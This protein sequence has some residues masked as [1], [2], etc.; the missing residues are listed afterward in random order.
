MITTET[1]KTKIHN[2]IN[3]SNAKTG[4]NDST[5][6]DAVNE[7][8]SGYGA[9]NEETQ[10]GFLTSPVYKNVEGSNYRLVYNEDFNG[11]DIDKNYWRDSHFISRVKNRYQAWTDYYLKDSLLHL[12]IRK[13]APNR[14][15]ADDDNDVFATAIQTGEVNKLH[16]TS[17]FYHDIHPFWGLITQEG[18]YECRFKVFKATGGCHTSWWCVGIQDGKYS[19][20]PRAEID[21][22]EILA[23]ATTN[24][25]HGVHRQSDD[26]VTESYTTTAVDVDFA[27]D[28]HTVG[29]LWENGIMKWYVD[30]V[31]VDTKEINTPQYPV[32]HYLSAYKRRSGTGWTGDA[33]TTLDDV[34]FLVDYLKI[35]KK[36]ESASDTNV[37]IVSQE[38]IEVSY[39]M[40]DAVVIDSDRGCPLN[41]PSYCY[42]K[43]SDGSRTEHWVKWDAVNDVK[44]EQILRAETIEWGGFVYGVGIEVSAT[45]TFVSQDEDYDVVEYADGI[46]T[47]ISTTTGAIINSDL[48][49]EYGSDANIIVDDYISIPVGGYCVS[50]DSRYPVTNIRVVMYNDEMQAI[51]RV[52]GY[53]NH[54]VFSVSEGIKYIRLSLSWTDN[55]YPTNISDVT[56]VFSSISQLAFE[57]GDIDSASGENVDSTLRLRSEFLSVDRTEI[58][59]QGSFIDEHGYAFRCYDADKRFIGSVTNSGEL[60]EDDSTSTLPDDTHYVRMLVQNVRGNQT[61]TESDIT[62]AQGVCIINGVEY[63]MTLKTN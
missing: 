57:I 6:T 60:F 43:W 51:G 10:N 8:L 44:R 22:T 9:S 59:V 58:T 56:I 36:A 7:L 11:T 16:I 42:I 35:Y 14:Y 5:L 29:F 46:Y 41:L 1:V 23:N 12:R 3:L 24:L 47:P 20:S 38:P 28:F 34:E 2:L 27:D 63:K 37:S 17:P 49:I 15:N 13:D 19:D 30:G 48:K 54:M 21:I 25:P 32:M 40:S 62:G 26:N 53:G 39:D 52:V 4:K 61:Y 33:D 50:V 55:D 45:I 18:Y 31:L